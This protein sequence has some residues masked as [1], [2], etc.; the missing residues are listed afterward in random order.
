M[1]LVLHGN[2]NRNQ[3][4]NHITLHAKKKSRKCICAEIEKLGKNENLVGH[5]E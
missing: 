3:L 4:I 1:L 5:D 2:A